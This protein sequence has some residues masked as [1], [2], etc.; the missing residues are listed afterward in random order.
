M[1]GMGVVFFDCTQNTTPKHKMILVTVLLEFTV[2]VFH[3]VEVHGDGTKLALYV[4]SVICNGS[5]LTLEIL[6]PG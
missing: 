5:I 1:I 4:Y 2:S 3:G 6:E